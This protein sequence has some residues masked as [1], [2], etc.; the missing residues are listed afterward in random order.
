LA[1]RFASAR[2]PR[3]F[4]PLDHTRW[5]LLRPGHI[6]FL[7]WLAGSVLLFG[8][9]FLFL[10]ALVISAL[11]PGAP[12]GG[13][14]PRSNTSGSSSIVTPPVTGGIRLKLTGSAT[15]ASGS[16]LHLLGQGFRP[17]SQITFWLDGRRALLDQRGR[18]ALA[19]ADAGG[20]FA[21][22]LW[23]GQGPGWSAGPH[24]ILAR[25]IGNGGQATISISIASPAVTPGSRSN[26]PG[27]R[28]TPP[29]HPTPIP[30]HPTP[31]HPT[32]PPP[33]PSP[34]TGITPTASP[35]G[36]NVPATPPSGSPTSVSEQAVNSSSLGN[37]LHTGDD[38]SLFARLFHLNPLIWLIGI[39]YLLSLLLLGLAGVF[40]RRRR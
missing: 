14:F 13:N 20:R 7:L 3:R 2:S 30:P 21:A 8:I 9:T 38:G 39:C 35:S 16:K 1:P 25:A 17:S 5:W 19:R 33:R 29:A 28:D 24:Q 18:S 36:T 15:L 31:A 40:H 12:V 11:L 37:D 4:S 34:T 27:P 10:L 32:P 26:N 6:E 23:L 22:D